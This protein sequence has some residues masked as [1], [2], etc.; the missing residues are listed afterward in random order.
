MID[1]WWSIWILIPMGPVHCNTSITY[2]CSYFFSKKNRKSIKTRQ[3]WQHNINLF[4][5]FL[6]KKIEK[7]SRQD[8]Y[9]RGGFS[10]K[11]SSTFRTFGLCHSLFPLLKQI[12]VIPKSMILTISIWLNSSEVTTRPLVYH[13]LI[14]SRPLVDYY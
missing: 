7:V 6:K 14:T 3:L 2:T 11:P 1:A 9:D 5:F 13:Y 12:I 8:S 4:I 10:W